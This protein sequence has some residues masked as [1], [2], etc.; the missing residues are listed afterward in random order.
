MHIGIRVY[1][2]LRAAFGLAGGAQATCR[3]LKAAGCRVL[4]VDLALPTHPP[5]DAASDLWA[6]GLAANGPVQV[7]PVQVDLVHTNPNI[8]EQMPALL[9]P[10]ALQAPIRIGYWAWELEQFPEGWQQ[11]FRGYDEIWCPSSFTAQALAQRAPLPV[12]ALPHLPDWP[13][14]EALRR[15]RLAARSGQ[16]P[17]EGVFRFLTLFDYWSTPERKNPEGVIA[18]FQ[19]AF[20][21]G[22]RGDPPVE[23]LI[24]TSSAEQFAPQAARLRALAGADPRIHWIEALLAPE[25]FEQLWLRA[26]ALVSLH[27]A[28][29]FGLV[30]AEAMA[31]GVPVI[32]TGYSGNLDFCLPGCVA[33][34][35]WQPVALPATAGDYPA[36]ATWAEPDADAAAAAMVQLAADRRAADALGER[37]RQAVRERLAPERLAGIIRQRLG[38]HL[39]PPDSGPE[40]AG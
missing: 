9:D 10:S 38:S 37:G 11:H 4:P 24:K 3:A 28:E 35:P 17:G 21:L 29:G 25:Q 12:V 6:P 18:A 13:R 30:M 36:G 7:E 15:R 40:A 19:R 1:G 39:L 34:I 8:L 31:L 20:P 22:R 26:D 33:L 14:L 5:L 23:L 32:A 2:H 27:R 16:P